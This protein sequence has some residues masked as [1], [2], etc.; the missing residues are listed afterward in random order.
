MHLQ[1][2]PA[3][4]LYLRLQTLRG[5]LG[6]FSFILLLSPGKSVMGPACLREA[7]PFTKR[8]WLSPLA[9]SCAVRELVS[10]EGARS[11]FT[12]ASFPAGRLRLDPERGFTLQPHPSW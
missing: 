6:A 3:Q 4:T 9:A 12:F 8:C 5:A 10:Y 7:A 1:L 2:G 11:V